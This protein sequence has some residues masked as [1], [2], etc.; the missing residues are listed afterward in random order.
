MQ[1]SVFACET[2]S[3]NLLTAANTVH[4]PFKNQS[5]CTNG[6]DNKQKNGANQHSL[7]KEKS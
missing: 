3:Q 6:Y 2:L 5:S 4:F 1:F 7:K